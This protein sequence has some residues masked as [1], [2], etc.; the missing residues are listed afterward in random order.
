MSLKTRIIGLLLLVVLLIS[1]AFSGCSIVDVSN[2]GLEELMQPPM[3][4]GEKYQIKLLLDTIK[5]GTV[6]FSSP[7]SGTFTTACTEY[8]LDGDGT[9]EAVAFYQEKENGVTTL[10]I[11]LF[12][13]GENGWEDVGR[14][15]A[16]DDDIFLVDFYDL[17]DDEED[18]IVVL[19]EN[20]EYEQAGKTLVVYEYDKNDGN[21]VSVDSRDCE[22]FTV[23]D[24]QNDGKL[25]IVVVTLEPEANVYVYKYDYCADESPSHSY[26]G[27][28]EFLQMGDVITLKDNVEV[29]GEVKIKGKINGYASVSSSKYV[30]IMD[31][32][33]RRKEYFPRVMV[34]CYYQI[35][36]ETDEKLRTYMIYCE[37]DESGFG[38]YK[39][40]PKSFDYASDLSIRESTVT[41]RDINNDGIVDLPVL[42]GF[43]N[44]VPDDATGLVLDNEIYTEKSMVSW[45]TYD[46][47]GWF[48]SEYTIINS[49]SNY[50]LTIP[51]EWINDIY[52]EDNS[53]EGEYIFYKWDFENKKTL[54]P[55]ITVKILYWEVKEDWESKG[56]I[57]VGTNKAGTL[58]YTMRK[59]NYEGADYVKLTISE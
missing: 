5:K 38:K 53:S 47:T 50:I 9:D 59:G 43:V 17:D 4:D 22:D 45:N 46:G 35:E 30:S 6:T 58:V 49:E 36:G 55:Y 10:Y 29:D 27:G 42:V 25:E 14:I 37:K 20:L 19:W 13:K 26:Y 32:N 40:E 18:E 41:S 21:I 48:N 44:T 34:D 51:K 57:S 8:D 7:K 24:L 54:E 12:H 23:V 3:P 2:L 52:F 16:G 31:G 39:D 1:F 15:P 33:G 11:H 28:R 56:Y